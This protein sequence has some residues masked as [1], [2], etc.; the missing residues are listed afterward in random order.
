MQFFEPVALRGPRP[1]EGLRNMT[2]MDSDVRLNLAGVDWGAAWKS[3]EAQRSKPGSVEHWSR[4]APSYARHSGKSDYSDEFLRRAAIEPG[5]TVLDFGCGTGILA[6]PLARQGCRVVACD[7]SPGM[8]QELGRAAEEAGVS[9]RIEAHLLSWEDDWAAQ[10]VGPGCA[11]VAI[12]SRSIATADLEAALAKLDAAA[13]RR[14]C[15]TVAAGRSPRRDERAYEAVGR[16]RNWTADYAYC[17]N[18]LFSH[19]IFPELSYI[20]SKSRPAFADK[21]EAA[22]ELADMMGGN[23]TAS[24]AAALDAFLD[25]HYAVDPDPATRPERRYASDALR[26]VRWAFISWDRQ[27]G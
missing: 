9:D 12:A 7:F 26:T 23:L 14:A 20:V 24:E 21:A 11:D 2:G 3:H 6:I 25:E 10:G 15:V 22:A 19:G 17:M 4:R 8:L 18:V 16:T 5:E 13:R 1:W 27:D